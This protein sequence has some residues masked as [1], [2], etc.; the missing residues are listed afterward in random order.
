V[1]IR[2]ALN[3]NVNVLVEPHVAR[4]DWVRLWDNR[5]SKTIKVSEHESIE[6]TLDIF[7]TTNV[8]T[9]TTLVTTQVA[10]GSAADY[11]KP[12]A[13]GGIDASAASSIIAPR[14]LR[15]GVRWRF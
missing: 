4:Y 8:N 3:T 15:F 11:G 10:G 7:N 5:I 12:L 13:G 9:V 1:Q 6:G 2:N 14:I